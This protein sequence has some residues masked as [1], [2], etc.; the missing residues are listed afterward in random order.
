MKIHHNE[1]GEAVRAGPFAQMAGMTARY[2]TEIADE[3]GV[4]VAMEGFDTGQA[5]SNL[6]YGCR[7]PRFHVQV[8]R[9]SESLC[10]VP[11]AFNWSSL[12]NE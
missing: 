5:R 12:V 3:K 10:A 11:K 9:I 7:N 4:N 2:Y 6:E 1:F 8:L